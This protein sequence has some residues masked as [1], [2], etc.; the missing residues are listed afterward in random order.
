MGK[1]ASSA[2]NEGVRVLHLRFG[3][4]GFI[5]KEGGAALSRFT[6]ACKLGL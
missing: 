1:A 2:K 6:P 5:G 3:S 4:V